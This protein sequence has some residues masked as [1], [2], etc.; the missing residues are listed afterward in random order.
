MVGKNESKYMCEVCKKVRNVIYDR[1]MHALMVSKDPTGLVTHADIHRCEDGIL[2]I[3]NCA[4]D[5]DGNIRGID[6]LQLPTKQVPGSK[7]PA[8]TIQA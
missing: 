1:E 7:L 3:N 4:I 6:N 2:G 5:A 8:S